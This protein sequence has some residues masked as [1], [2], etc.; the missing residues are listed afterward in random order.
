MLFQT[1]SHLAL[2]ENV[3]KFAIFFFAMIILKIALA[4]NNFCKKISAF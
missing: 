2:H 4:L 1:D 3:E